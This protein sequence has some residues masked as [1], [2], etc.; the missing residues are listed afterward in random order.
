MTSEADIKKLR[1]PELKA[2]LERLGLPTGG[3]KPVLV[4]RL[5]AHHAVSASFLSE[6][7]EDAH[8]EDAVMG[9]KEEAPAP[10]TEPV[11]PEPV[12]GPAPAPVVARVVAPVVTPVPTPAGAHSAAPVATASPSK[13]VAVAVA[14]APVVQ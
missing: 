5:L 12:H 9:G 6:G 10:E 8:A 3:L 4:E 2:E 11:A 13:P 1:V 14:A 7:N